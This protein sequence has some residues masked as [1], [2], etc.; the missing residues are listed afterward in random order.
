M[1]EL[2]VFII[3][4]PNF[5]SSKTF[6]TIPNYKLSI[7][8][9]ANFLKQKLCG[10]CIVVDSSYN[11]GGSLMVEYGTVDPMAGVRFPLTALSFNNK[12][13]DFTALKPNS[14]ISD[15]CRFFSKKPGTSQKI[16]AAIASEQNL[17]NSHHHF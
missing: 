4:S 14:K 17:I 9:T 16:F 2:I 12:A 13:P 5:S 8:L 7:D 1:K 11:G 15:S 10:G 6:L 3:N